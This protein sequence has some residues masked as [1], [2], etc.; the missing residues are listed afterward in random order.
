MDR[1]PQ[2]GLVPNTGICKDSI[3]VRSKA[4][5][6]APNTDISCCSD[7]VGLFNYIK[8]RKKGYEKNWGRG[9]KLISY[10]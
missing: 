9:S 3:K 1:S 10:L 2:A 7:G 6:H 5:T 8:E 4:S